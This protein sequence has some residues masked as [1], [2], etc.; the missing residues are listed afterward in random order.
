MDK[1]IMCS[2]CYLI[3][4]AVVKACGSEDYVRDDPLQR[5]RECGL[6]LSEGLQFTDA[7]GIHKSSQKIFEIEI[8]PFWPLP[9]KLW[10][11]G[12]LNQILLP[13][14]GDGHSSEDSLNCARR[15]KSGV[16]DFEL[17]KAWIQ[18]CRSCH[19]E[20]RDVERP[21]ALNRIASLRFLDVERQCL[22]QTVEHCRY[23][24]LSYVWGN[25]QVSRLREYDLELLTREGALKNLVIHRTIQDAITVVQRIGERY[26]WVDS[27]C[28]M[29]DSPSDQKML[30]E[31]G[32]LYSH[33]VL[34]I[35]VAHGVDADAGIPGVQPGSRHIDQ[36]IT[37]IK[38]DLHLSIS[39]C[40]T[41]GHLDHSPW[42]FQRLDLPRKIDVSS[43]AH[44]PT[45]TGILALLC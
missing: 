11:V 1:R 14:I 19:E 9:V 16:I 15:L 44:F 41:K 20:C 4:E 42:K 21:G 38:P 2:F 31:M 22:T 6:H 7:A 43:D 26:L 12:H 39:T 3:Y 36:V 45:R 27:L 13:R 37:E 10:N 32:A 28:L 25:A 8:K 33:A 34:T 24:A 29:Q 23:V 17:V 18:Q 35:V 30:A 5:S 40:P